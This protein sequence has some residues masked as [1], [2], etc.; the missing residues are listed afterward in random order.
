MKQPLRLI[1]G[2]AELTFI[3][4]IRSRLLM[5]SG[6]VGALAV[7][8]GFVAAGASVWS[9]D[10]FVVDIGLLAASLT[11]H[12]VACALS[13]HLLSGEAH[14]HSEYMLL[15]R[16]LTRAQFLLGRFLGIAGLLLVLCQSMLLLT[17]GGLLGAQ[18]PLPQALWAAA[19][20]TTVEVWMTA[21][22]GCLFAAAS[23]RALATTLCVL[24]FL[25][26][27]AAD[28]VRLLAER[29]QGTAIGPWLKGAYHVL[30]DYSRLSLRDV[31]AAD[32]PIPPGTL[33]WSLAYAAAYIGVVTAL[34]CVV[35]ERR[36][37]RL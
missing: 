3:E 8:L 14:R 34:A 22:L 32:M 23:S 37:T 12:V 29:K 5:A 24:L 16:P 19:A 6:L 31:V 11:G 7:L 20:M 15:C 9:R 26:G 2:I 33:T 13:T 17:L 35:Y 28:E 4:A 25:A 10:R 21:A 30:P 36:A 18:A 27:Q 1:A